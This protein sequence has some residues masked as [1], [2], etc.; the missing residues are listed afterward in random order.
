M[1]PALGMIAI[2][3]Q[4]VSKAFVLDH[5][6]PFLARE[7]LR[8]IVSRQRADRRHWA[9]RDISFEIGS[10]ETVGVIGA[11]GSGKSTLLSLMAGT[12]YP[13]SGLAEVKGRIGPLLELGAGFHPLLTGEENI[14]LNAYLLGM[15]REEVESR[16]D[17]IIEYSELRPFID[18]PISKYSTGMIARLGFAVLAHMRPDVLLIDEALSVGDASFSAKC[19]ETIQE[20]L[21]SGTTVVIVSHNLPSIERLCRRAIWI[22]KGE[23]RA[24]GPAHD[25]CSRYWGHIGQA[26]A[27]ESPAPA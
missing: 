25:V 1:I 21:R 8:R 12:S 19:E 2:R 16:L 6:R 3:F 27:T 4:N 7:V 13:T 10:G 22:D 15:S 24:D 5:Q 23:L 14:V 17:S 9:L 18:T 20:F 11:N 26:R